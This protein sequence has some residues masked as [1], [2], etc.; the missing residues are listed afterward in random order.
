MPRAIWK[1]HISFG[2]VNVPVTLYSAE[3]KTDLSFSLVDSRNQA[4]VRYQRVN[5]LTGEEVPWEDVAKAFEYDDGNYLLLS[6]E[7][8]EKVAV[9]ASKT[10]EI[11]DFVE[12]KAVDYVYFDKPYILEPGTK[13]EK[14][15]VLLREV[16]K[17]TGKIGIARVVIRT[18]EYL[19]A[20]MPQG[21]A[22][23]LDLLRFHQELRPEEE[24]DLP[25]GDVD[26]YGISKKEIDMAEKLVEGMAGEWEPEKYHDEYREALLKWIHE[27]IEEEGGAKSAELPEPAGKEPGEVVDFMEL[28][29]KSVEE[30]TKKKPASRSKKKPAGKKKSAG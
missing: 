6:K 21:D 1:G 25:G 7:D 4:R 15:Y 3:Q 20:L 13:G 27:K 12:Q 22:L 19:A 2:L 30:K 11:E 9:E 24:F 17:S 28:L 16:L 8:F 10:I 26:D 14:G 18:K 5:E 23:I 29:K